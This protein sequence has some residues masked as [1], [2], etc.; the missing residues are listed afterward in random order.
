[1]ERFAARDERTRAADPEAVIIFP[2]AARLSERAIARR[3]NEM[4]ITRAA[5]R[6]C[7]A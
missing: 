5:V 4:L 1:V 7:G 2:R 6:R 3:G